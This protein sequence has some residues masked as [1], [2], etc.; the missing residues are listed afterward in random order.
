MHICSRGHS[1]D[2][3]LPA[4]PKRYRYVSDQFRVATVS[5]ETYKD[6]DEQHRYLGLY[7]KSAF[8]M[9]NQDYV[10]L[11]SIRLAP[12]LMSLSLRIPVLFGRFHGTYQPSS[13]SICMHLRIKN[14]ETKLFIIIYKESNKWLFI[15]MANYQLW[16]KISP[17]QLW[18]GS[19]LV[20]TS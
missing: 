16:L 19:Q 11:L 18:L 2:T 9:Y 20:T 5:K 1:V 15:H 4:V 12:T 6:G 3:P 8:L 10:P 14:R 17:T 13:F 7:I